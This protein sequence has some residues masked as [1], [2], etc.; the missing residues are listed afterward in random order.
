[1]KMDDKMQFLQIVISERENGVIRWDEIARKMNIYLYER[2]VY[3]NL[4]YFFEDD[5]CG[6]SSSEKP[7]SQLPLHFELWPYIEEAQSACGDE[8]LAQILICTFQF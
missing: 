4:A 3:G 8:S 7:V 6:P 1:M 2:R 5:I